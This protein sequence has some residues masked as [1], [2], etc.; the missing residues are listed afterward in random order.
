MEYLHYIGFDVHKKTIQY[1]T[2]LANGDIVQ[3]GRI[4]ATRTTL[5]NWAA[6]QSRPWKGAMEATMF[7]AWIYDTLL[8]YARELKVAHP[9]MLKA[10]TAS[11]HASDRLDA[12]Q[13]ADLVRMEW[14][15]KVWM[16]PP[17]IRSSRLLLRYR[18]LVVRQAT[19]TKN[20]IASV[21]MEHGVEYAKQ[22]LH[23]RGYF[24]ELLGRLEEVPETV[25]HLLRTSRVGVELFASTQRALLRHLKSDRVLA[26]RVALLDTVPGV[27]EVTALTWAL[28]VGDPHRF[29]SVGRALSYCGL[30]APQQESAGKSYRQPLS[31]KRNAHLQTMLIE[32]A[33][34]APRTSP[35]LRAL[36]ERQKKRRHAGAAAIAVARKLVAYLL[37]VD[38]SGQPFQA[39]PTADAPGSPTGKSAFPPEPPIEE[40][41]VARRSS[42]SRVRS[43]AAGPSASTPSGELPPAAPRTAPGRRAGK[44]S[45]MGG[46]NGKAARRSG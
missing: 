19:Q 11:K 13:I 46:S 32:A 45:A 1:C 6:G 35:E 22:K 10:I 2:K 9:A 18:N 34:L 41:P 3:E 43:A 44:A 20:R 42:P 28:E 21:L 36:Y 30:V 33:H 12:R 26:Q 4:A 37:A 38:K 14:I 31:K 8:P 15:P 23:Q 24:Q 7:T 25:K 16:A 27:G 29:A 5:L 17:E 40:R 39:R